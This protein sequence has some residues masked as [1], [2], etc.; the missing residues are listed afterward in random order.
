MPPR[1]LCAVVTLLQTPV[2]AGDPLMRASFAAFA[3]GHAAPAGATRPGPR[4]LSNALFVADTQPRNDRD[5]SSLVFAWA[6]VS[7]AGVLVQRLAVV[8]LLHTV[9]ASEVRGPM[10]VG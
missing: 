1:W 5:M 7:L 3:D 8:L 4:A 10:R 6:Q 9:Q 2:A